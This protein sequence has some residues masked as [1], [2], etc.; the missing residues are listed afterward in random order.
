MLHNV[1]VIRIQVVQRLT[2]SGD[3]TGVFNRVFKEIR[4]VNKSDNFW[5]L[6]DTIA[7]LSEI[8]RKLLARCQICCPVP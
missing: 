7:S 8:L 1:G 3:L 4:H 2:N 5:V 6:S